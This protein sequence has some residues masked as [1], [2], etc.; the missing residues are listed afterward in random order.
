MGIFTW[1]ALADMMRK[2]VFPKIP[3]ERKQAE[4]MVS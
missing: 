3:E 2:L 4:D 1:D